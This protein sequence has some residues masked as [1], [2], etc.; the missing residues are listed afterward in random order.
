[1]VIWKSP[2]RSTIW[3]YLASEHIRLRIALPTDENLLVRN[4]N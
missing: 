3:L 2:L 1:M 4:G